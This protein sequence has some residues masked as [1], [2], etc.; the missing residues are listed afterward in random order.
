[1][2]CRAIKAPAIIVCSKEFSSIVKELFPEMEVDDG[3]FNANDLA[4]A[5]SY[6]S[7]KYPNKKIII[8]QQNGT[9]QEL[10]L[11]FRNYQKF[12]EY[13]ASSEGDNMS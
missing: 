8:S 3:D 12:Q 6:A 4:S 10:M 5:Y 1:M 2:V 9:K 7:F 11:P 13:Y